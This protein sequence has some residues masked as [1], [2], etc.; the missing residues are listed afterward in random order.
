MA[1]EFLY[2]YEKKILELESRRHVYD[3][4][5]KHAGSH[6]RELERKCSISTGLVRYHL[7]YLVKTG[8]IIEQKDGKNT[9]Y[10]P[11][12]ITAQSKN[13]LGLLRQ[14]SLRK[15]ILSLFIQDGSTHDEIA[16]AVKLSLSTVTWHL[17]KLSENHIIKSEKYGRKT[18]YTIIYDKEEIIKLLI[19]YKES[20]LD[21]LVDRIIDMWD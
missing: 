4:V 14:D 10:F 11:K 8:L 12:Q 9:R 17:K 21:S 15:I 18:C 2:E 7:S 6:F 5:K 19:T 13:L 16:K 20:F 1:E 3:A